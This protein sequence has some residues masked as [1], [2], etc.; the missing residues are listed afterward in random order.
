MWKNKVNLNDIWNA[1]VLWLTEDNALYSNI[2]LCA[3]PNEL[4]LELNDEVEFQE[5]NK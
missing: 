4:L 3:N 1:L 5:A 2:T